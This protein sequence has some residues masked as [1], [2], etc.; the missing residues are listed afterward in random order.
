MKS[1][2]SVTRNM[3]R[4]D[5]RPRG[6]RC[7]RGASACLLEKTR[8]GVALGP[9]HGDRTGRFRSISWTHQ[10]LALWR[11]VCSNHVAAG[12]RQVFARQVFAKLIGCRQLAYCGE[13]VRPLP[14]PFPPTTTLHRS[15]QQGNGRM[16]SHPALGS[17]ADRAGSGVRRHSGSPAFRR[18]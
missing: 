7:G 9:A 11:C 10:S 17:S 6:R 15:D 12:A 1:S 13:I 14:Q 8:E 18:C 2:I 5:R 4:T 3:M 16:R